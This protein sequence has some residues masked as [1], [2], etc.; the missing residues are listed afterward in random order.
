MPYTATKLINTQKNG[1]V[2]YHPA[3]VAEWV[4]YSFAMCACD[5]CTMW[6]QRPLGPLL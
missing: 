5:F 2:L 6:Q 4:A 3:I 1:I